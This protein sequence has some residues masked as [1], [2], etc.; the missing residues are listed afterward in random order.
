[1]YKDGLYTAQCWSFFQ[2]YA[3]TDSWYAVLQGSIGKSTGE[4]E[5]LFTWWILRTK[6][7]I[8][9]LLSFS[10]TTNQS[11]NYQQDIFKALEG[12]ISPSKEGKYIAILRTLYCRLMNLLTSVI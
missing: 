10:V 9:I 5:W 8:V 11:N 4:G 1:M 12:L 2:Y 6:D 7:P 3:L